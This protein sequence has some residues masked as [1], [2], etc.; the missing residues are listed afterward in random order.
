FVA[1]DA[2]E[3][4]VARDDAVLVL[5]QI[6]QQLELAARQAYRRAIDG[7][8]DGVEIGAEPLAAIQRRAHRAVVASRAAAAQ[9]GAHPRG[10]LA[11]AER[12]GDVIVGAVLEAGYAIVF[13][14]A[15]GEHDDRHVRHVGARSQD[16][17]DVKTVDDR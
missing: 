8:G 9:H 12:L 15:G 14:G 13:A 6:L 5:D 17:A 4:T 11:E 2:L 1:P 10:Q 7:N 16:A 3:E